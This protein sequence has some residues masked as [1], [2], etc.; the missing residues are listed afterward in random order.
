MPVFFC[1]YISVVLQETILFFVETHGRASL[2]SKINTDND[3][4]YMA[5]PWKSPNNSPACP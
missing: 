1:F 2:H 4:P 5:L 3:P